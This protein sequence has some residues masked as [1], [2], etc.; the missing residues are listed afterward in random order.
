MQKLEMTIP[1]LTGF[2]L[3]EAYNIVRT[4]LMFAGN[5][6]KSVVITSSHENEGK[7]TVAWNLALSLAGSSKKVLFIDADMRKS[8]FAGRMHVRNGSVGLS[9]YLSGQAELND[10]VYST[11]MENLY[12][13]M[14]GQFPPNPSE[15]LSHELFG[16]MIKT[17]R[18]EFD[19][20]LVDTPPVMSVIDAAVITSV[21]DASIIIISY[22]RRSR[23]FVQITMDQLKRTGK[24]ILGAVLNK[25]DEDNNSAYGRYYNKYYGDH[26]YKHYY[27]SYGYGTNGGGESEDE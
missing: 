3:S 10:V 24:P 21:C 17:L 25:V 5:D 14:C 13:M 18:Q 26:Y 6:I 9:H 12:V 2:R 11:D 19:Y 20:I 16:N 7:S 15:L 23:R 22:N 8:V 27:S 4:N 1:K